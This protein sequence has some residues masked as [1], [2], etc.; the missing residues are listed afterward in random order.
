MYEATAQGHLNMGEFQPLNASP[1]TY[2]KKSTKVVETT[3]LLY[4]TIKINLK[5]FIE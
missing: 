4:I 5:F 3:T 2:R 1:E